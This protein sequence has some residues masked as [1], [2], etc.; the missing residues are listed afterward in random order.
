ME[1]HAELAGQLIALGVIVALFLLLVFL[2]RAPTRVALDR[3]DYEADG[4]KRT[5]SKGGAVPDEA[6]QAA[7]GQIKVVRRRWLT[8]IVVGVDHRAS[9]SKTVAF[10]WTLVIA[11]GLLAL[12]VAKWWGSSTGW[13]AQLGDGIQADYLVLLGG[14]YAAAVLARMR[15]TT[16]AGE[17]GKPSGAA[18]DA[19]PTQIVSDDEN[20]TSL[21]DF[22]YVLFNL[23][24]IAYF[25]GEFTG[26]LEHGFPDLPDLLSG[27]VL[28][29]VAGYSA[30]KFVAAAK[31]TLT[32][33]L[34]ISG[35]PGAADVK[36][37]GQNLVLPALGAEPALMPHVAVG[38][39]PATVTAWQKILGADVLTITLHAQATPVVGTLSVVRADGIAAVGPAGS[40]GIA[41]TVV[42]PAASSK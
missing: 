33:V 18:Q 35:L 16:Q 42:S 7:A 9:T 13:D 8:G 38:G 21:G 11:Y 3:I 28:T 17:G 24:A 39:R 22:Q 6:L 19:S 37:Y 12:L 1:E 29:S 2:R 30:T 41:F 32:S 5:V 4:V 26:N 15:A 23:I 14:P 10:A 31:P 36:V 34:P 40:D 25:L 27:L 20:R